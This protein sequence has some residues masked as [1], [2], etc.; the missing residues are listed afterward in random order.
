MSDINEKALVK[1]T[2]EIVE[3][4]TGSLVINSQPSYQ[5]VADLCSKIVDQRKKISGFFKPLKDAAHKS[6]KMLCDR[7]KEFLGPLE[8]IERKA[9]QNMGEWYQKQ[10]T[11][12][13]EKEEKL[14]AEA[15]RKAEEER[16]KEIAKLKAAGEKDVA[17]QLAQVP[18]VAAEVSVANKAERSDMKFVKDFEI[19]VTDINLVPDQ[20]ITKTLKLMEVKAF[21][22]ANATEIPGLSI[23][24]FMRPAVGGR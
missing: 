1:A 19:T 8:D 17:K 5:R 16:A 10:E 18:V 14:R 24:E 20:F 2:T 4:V 21:I 23:R 15:Q 3:E 12:R 9:K 11:I 22:K 7:E 6:W 13:R